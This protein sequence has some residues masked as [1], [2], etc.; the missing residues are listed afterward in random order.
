MLRDHGRGTTLNL[1]RAGGRPLRGW[2][3]YPRNRSPSG[4][5]LAA[6]VELKSQDIIKILHKFCKNKDV[7]EEV[8]E[9]IKNDLQSILEL[10]QNIEKIDV[11]RKGKVRRARL[12]YMRK[13]KGK[14]AKIKQKI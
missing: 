6:S 14:Q 10:Q 7:P 9:F 13:R 8:K 4:E 1:H 12:F 5:V 3:Q 11:I 2:A